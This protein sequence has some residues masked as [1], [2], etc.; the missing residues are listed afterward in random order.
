MTL[1]VL[2]NN[3]N[4]SMSYLEE[5]TLNLVEVLKWKNYLARKANLKWVL[6]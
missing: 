1:Q 2:L 4:M 6:L 5:N 3:Q